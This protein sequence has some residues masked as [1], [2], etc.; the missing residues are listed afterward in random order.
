MYL[1][2]GFG[3]ATQDAGIDIRR[4]AMTRD[5]AIQLASLYDNELPE[6][7]IQGYLDYYQMSR[8]E[9]DNVLKK[10]VNKDLFKEDGNRFLPTFE[11]F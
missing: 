9:F 4:G 5:Q 7:Y 2:F 10:W 11:I 3:R 8:D 6:E 1:K